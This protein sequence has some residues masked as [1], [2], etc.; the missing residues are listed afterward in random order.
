M[1]G[2]DCKSGGSKATNMPKRVLDAA[3]I[4]GG[5]LSKL[6]GE[7]MYVLKVR[8][9]DESYKVVNNWVSTLEG[10]PRV[11]VLF[12]PPNNILGTV[13]CLPMATWA[14]ILCEASSIAFHY[15]PLVANDFALQHPVIP[16][17]FAGPVGNIL[18]HH[19][20]IALHALHA[21]IQNAND[22]NYPVISS[23]PSGS[24][25]CNVTTHWANVG[26]SVAIYKN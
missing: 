9:G 7:E 5:D 4:E 18:V 23:L 2:T 22:P 14:H 25:I 15:A 10:D 13:I 21:R 1:S 6:P 12:L 16:G 26:Y 20:Q 24:Y 17:P 3:V 11:D 8:F 19:A